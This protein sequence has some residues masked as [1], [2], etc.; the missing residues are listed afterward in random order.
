MFIIL[1]CKLWINFPVWKDLPIKGLFIYVIGDHRAIQ[2]H[3][4]EILE[5]MGNTQD[6][7]G[8]KTE[9]TV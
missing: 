2:T 4:Q 7:K 1:L 9:C 6:I 3:F 5:D 8:H